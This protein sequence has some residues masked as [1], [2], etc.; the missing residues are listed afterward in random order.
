MCIFAE[1]FRRVSS[2]RSSGT[3]RDLNLWY[4]KAD[5]SRDGFVAPISDSRRMPEKYSG[6]EGLHVDLW[7]Q[8]SSL[9]SGLVCDWQPQL[10]KSGSINAHGKKIDSRLPSGRGAGSIMSSRRS[11]DRKGWEPGLNRFPLA[12]RNRQLGPCC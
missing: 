2:G 5:F 10:P 8:T 12:T 1:P 4:Q 7:Y 3:R 6:A 9:S 11:T